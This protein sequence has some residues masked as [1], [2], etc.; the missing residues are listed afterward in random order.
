LAQ[1]QIPYSSGNYYVHPKSFKTSGYFDLQ[2]GDVILVPAD[3]K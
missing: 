2:V 1:D 3:D